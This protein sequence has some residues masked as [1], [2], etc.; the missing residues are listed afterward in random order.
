[1]ETKKRLKV[2]LVVLC[3]ALVLSLIALA[4]MFFLEN[5]L[6]YH[7]KVYPKKQDVLDLTGEALTYDDYTYLSQQLEETRIIWNAPLSDGAVS[8]DHT[9]ITITKLTKNDLQ[10]LTTFE[11]LQ[12][13]DGS[14]C[15]DYPEMMLLQQQKPSCVVSY[16]VPIGGVV[17]Q[18]NAKAVETPNLDREQLAMLAYLPQLET[19][20][21]TGCTDYHLLR[22]VAESHPEWNVLYQV[23]LGDRILKQDTVTATVQNCTYTELTEKL[24]GLPKLKELQLV[25]PEATGEELVALR[26]AY[27][28]IAIHW[29]IDILGVEATDETTELDLSGIP[30][31]DLDELSTQA[32]KLPALEKLIMSD[33]GIDNETM[34]AFREQKRS[35]YKVVWTVH[36]TSWCKARTD[37]TIFMPYKQGWTFLDNDRQVRNL[38]YCEDMVCIDVGHSTFSDVSWAAYMPHLKYLVLAHT[39]VLNI[40]ALSN[41]KELV[42]LELDH[43]TV[44]DYSPLV[45]C[46]ALED[47]NLGKTHRSVTPI[48]Q[49]TWLKNL[50][51]MDCSYSN[52]KALEEAL[53]NT[54]RVYPTDYTVGQGWR[55]LPNYYAMRDLL[56][57]P[58]MN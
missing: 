37:D 38:K 27:D 33:C 29:Q 28:Q 5:N 13:V 7:G 3:A 23:A 46:T 8:S 54:N 1:M 21:A 35:E 31:T 12:E 36:M 24:Y 26:E 30:V 51:W 56:G 42:F 25:N 50:W 49:M 44:Q 15:M 32:N 45:E 4:V 34:A 39:H 58:Y 47:L 53:P 11:D 41:C 52:R 17:Y 19:V 9:A 18:Q 6:I 2:V 48:L 14:Q 10:L 43:T 55:K 20:N 40:S 16:R 22:E 57:M